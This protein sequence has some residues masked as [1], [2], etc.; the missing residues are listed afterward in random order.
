[1]PVANLAP[2]A[3]FFKKSATAENFHWIWFVKCKT[4]EINLRSFLS[5]P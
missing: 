4:M 2:T 3:I 1:M 5:F